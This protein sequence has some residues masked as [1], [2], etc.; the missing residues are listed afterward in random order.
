MIL[1]CSIW[2]HEDWSDKSLWNSRNLVWTVFYLQNIP[3]GAG[4]LCRESRTGWNLFF[5]EGE[6][7]NRFKHCSD[8]FG[9]GDLI[10]YRSI[11]WNQ[12]NIPMHHEKECGQTL[13]MWANFRYAHIPEVVGPHGIPEVEMCDI[14]LEKQDIWKTKE[15]SDF[16][17]IQ[18]WTKMGE[19]TVYGV[20]FVK[21]QSKI[22]IKKPGDL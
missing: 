3:H 2:I 19:V 16:I 18:R 21:F 10:T 15:G 13:P 5:E 8:R 11:D 9:M 4:E 1:I 12:T 22:N 17:L 7:M 20:L 6:Y 14:C